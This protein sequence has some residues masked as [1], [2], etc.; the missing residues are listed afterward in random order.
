MNKPDN[1]T[2]AEWQTVQDTIGA[3]KAAVWCTALVAAVA[4]I[5][6][7]CGEPGRAIICGVLA[8]CCWSCRSPELPPEIQNKMSGYLKTF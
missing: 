2:S 4:L 8:A 3:A 6:L 5:C 7:L 1:F